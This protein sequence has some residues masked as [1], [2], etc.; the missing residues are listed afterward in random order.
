MNPMNPPPELDRLSLW[1]WFKTDNRI[2]IDPAWWSILAGCFFMLGLI[3]VNR[4]ICWRYNLD[5]K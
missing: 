5:D 1:I 3:S 2:W 4:V